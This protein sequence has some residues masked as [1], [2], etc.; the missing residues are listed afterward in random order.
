VS[1]EENRRAIDRLI[2]GLEVDTDDLATAIASRA[3]ERSAVVDAVVRALDSGEPTVRL[4]AVERIGRM[5]DLAPRLEAALRR[6]ALDD[7]DARVRAAGA[8]ALRRHAAEH[9]GGSGGAADAPRRVLAAIALHLLTTRSGT[10]AVV[11][12]AKYSEDAPNLV[13]ELVAEGEDPVRLSVRGL[14]EPLIGTRPELH[15]LTNR[16]A[17]ELTAVGAASMPVST[18]GEVT[19]EIVGGVSL[20]ELERWFGD[21]AE[22]VVPAG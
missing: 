3:M 21:T 11:L 2:A 8:L 5:P 13:A 16:D 9:P 6:V 19:I 20:D 1:A 4:R 17:R 18:T 22:L 10:T 7:E 12:R 14:P 15:V